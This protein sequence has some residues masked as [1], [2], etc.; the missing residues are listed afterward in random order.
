MKVV[1]GSGIDS[2]KTGVI[3]DRSEVQANGRG[4]PSNVQGHYKPT[5]W[6]RE[7]AVKLDD[8]SLIT[9]FKKNRLVPVA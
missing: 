9:M 8:G 2:D 5:D 7:V 6:S 4:I 1:G 3:V